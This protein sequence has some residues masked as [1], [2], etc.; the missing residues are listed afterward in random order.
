MR[1][2]VLRLVAAPRLPQLVFTGTQGSQGLAL[3][4]S[5]SAASQLVK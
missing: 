5:T 3:G 1:L 4:L 2:P